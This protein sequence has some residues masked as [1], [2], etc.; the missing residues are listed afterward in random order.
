MEKQLFVRSEENQGS[1][2]SANEFSFPAESLSVT[3][4]VYANPEPEFETVPA[5][6]LIADSVNDPIAPTN[7]LVIMRL[8][9]I[10]FM[11][12]GWFLSR[13]YD[14]PIYLVLGLA[15][16]A[17]GLDPA[18]T[19]PRRNG[20]WLSVSLAVEVLLIMFVYLVVR[21]RH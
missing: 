2:A 14:T 21:L 10:S 19:E 20:R 12:T 3:E 13:T 17:I 15:T 7:S 16:A 1:D 18:A 5:G 9:L 8:A 11:T 6:H 4:A